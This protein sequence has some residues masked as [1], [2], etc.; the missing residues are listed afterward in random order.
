M[1]GAVVKS[2]GL[3]LKPAGDRPSAALFVSALKASGPVELD[4]EFEVILKRLPV[5][6]C[7]SGENFDRSEECMVDGV[8]L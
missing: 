1:R 8:A 4:W 5:E 2:R 7:I 6:Y 3:A